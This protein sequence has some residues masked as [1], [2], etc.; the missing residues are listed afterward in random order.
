M[1]G[2][3]DDLTPEKELKAAAARLGK[4]ALQALKRGDHD[5]ADFMARWAAHAEAGLSPEVETDGN[6]DD[7]DEDDGR[8]R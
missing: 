8:G 1:S 4:Q 7:G 2:T 6:S 3:P 5:Q